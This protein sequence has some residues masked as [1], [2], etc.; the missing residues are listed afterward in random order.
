MARPRIMHVK[1]HLQRFHR[2]VIWRVS[3][4]DGAHGVGV[5]EDDN[6]FLGH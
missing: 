1:R 3:V 6:G 2:L 5:G 4:K